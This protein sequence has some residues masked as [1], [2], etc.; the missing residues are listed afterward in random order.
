LSLA[1]IP[2][3]SLCGY[4][5]YM[6]NAT[7]QDFSQGLVYVSSREGELLIKDLV[8][9]HARRSLEKLVKEHGW[10]VVDTPL[11]RALVD[12]SKLDG[13]VATGVDSISGERFMLRDPETG[14]FSGSW[15]K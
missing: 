9:T 11:G 2:E 6:D 13:H 5:V 7:S 10:N 3:R 15:S 12:R 14:C 4:V 8:T 1:G